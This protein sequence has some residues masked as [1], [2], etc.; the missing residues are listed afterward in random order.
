MGSCRTLRTVSSDGI[1]TLNGA[2]ELKVCQSFAALRTS[3]CRRIIGITS[4]PDGRPSTPAARRCSRN[5]SGISLMIAENTTQ[6]RR[7]N[8]QTAC[9]P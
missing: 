7:I 3:A 8:R 2:S 6:A 1:G 5:G 4:L 9:T